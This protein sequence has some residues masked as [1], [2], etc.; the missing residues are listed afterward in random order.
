MLQELCS[1]DIILQAY[2][3]CVTCTVPEFI[4]TDI[5]KFVNKFKR[6]VLSVRLGPFVLTFSSVVIKSPY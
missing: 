4:K 2:G 3:R 5:Q 1:V 6:A